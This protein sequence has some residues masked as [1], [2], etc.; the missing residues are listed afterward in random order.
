MNCEEINFITYWSL[1]ECGRFN[2]AERI[3][4][5]R[6]SLRARH[7]EQLLKDV[8]KSRDL[9]CRYLETSIELLTSK[10]SSQNDCR[11]Q[12]DERKAG[13]E[14]KRRKEQK[15]KE[16]DEGTTAA[17]SRPGKGGQP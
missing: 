2:S 15:D 16:I 6:D 5:H 12:D 10:I 11:S 8:C 13:T 17:S 14:L 1:S 4:D 9:V 7:R 3:C